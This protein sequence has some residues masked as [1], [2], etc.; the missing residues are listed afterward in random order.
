MITG[1][2]GLLI[3]TSGMLFLGDQ[4][5]AVLAV[6]SSS[7]FAWVAL[8]LVLV[9]AFGYFLGGVLVGRMSSARTILEP[10]IAASFPAAI[11]LLYLL[12]SLRSELYASGLFFWSVFFSVLVVLACFGVALLGGYWGEKWQ[13]YVEKKGQP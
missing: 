12:G 13:R 4:I 1:L 5:A 9:A 2:Q 11:F 8:Q 3:G 7:G 6:P 10:A